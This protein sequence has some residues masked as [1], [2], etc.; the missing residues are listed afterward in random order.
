MCNLLP[1]FDIL[2]IRR[3]RHIYARHWAGSV[4]EPELQTSLSCCSSIW[5]SV[6][7]LLVASAITPTGYDCRHIDSA[8]AYRNEKEVGDAVRE[9]GLRRQDV[10]VSVYTR[11]FMS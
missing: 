3:R 10:F 8:R 9:S 4:P 11:H 5:L 7:R 1:Q 6:R 2:C